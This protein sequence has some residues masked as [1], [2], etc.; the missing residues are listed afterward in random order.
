MQKILQLTAHF[1]PNVGGVETHLDDLVRGLVEKKYQV[2]VLTYLP[3]TAH[4]DAK[5]WESSNNLRILR[6]PWMTGLFYKLVKNP[7]LEFLYLSPGLFIVTP[8]VLLFS[9]PDVIH[10]HGLIAGAVGVLWGKLF[11]I[12]TITTTH[13]LYH[14][15]TKGL[16]KTFAKWIFGTSSRVLTLSR[17]SKGEIEKLGI[18]SEKIRVF[19][20]WVD[21]NKFKKI[22]D[23]KKELGWEKKF[24]V[25]FVGRLVEEKGI[26]V[27]LESVKSWNKQ[28]YLVVAGT[29]PLEGFVRNEAKKSKNLGY[30][31]K[32]DNDKLPLYYSAADLVTVPSTHDEGFGRV[33]LES[34]ACGTPVVAANRG[35]IP[36]AMD[37]RVGEL[38]DINISNIAKS[39]SNF[40]NNPN[41][42]KTMSAKAQ[43]FAKEKYSSNNI[44]T[45]ITSYD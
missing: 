37:N 22:T 44:R 1:S 6:I 38:I 45:I 28:I 36:E 30:V 24:V 19:T 8:L 17:Q 4:A 16:Y 27:L 25:F 39:V 9:R 7:I 18:E 23:A 31:G 13:S 11:G 15:P 21:L 40:Y 14:F 26:L 34:L 20:Y 43:K 10:T 3:L 29:G 12:K 33:I 2:F 42:L 41:Q 5:I 32:I 35:A